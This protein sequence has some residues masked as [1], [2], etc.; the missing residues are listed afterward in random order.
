MADGYLLFRERKEGVICLI[1]LVTGRLTRTEFLKT[2]AFLER[3][4]YRQGILLGI[5]GL[6][7]AVIFCTIEM[8]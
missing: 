8:M 5:N 1:E 7:G 3:L 2:R 4:S 6:P